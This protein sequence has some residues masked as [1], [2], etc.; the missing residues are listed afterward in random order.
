MTLTTRLSAADN[1]SIDIQPGRW[2]LLLAQQDS[3]EGDSSVSLNG[4]RERVLL[5]AASGR[6]IRYTNSFASKRKLPLE[7]LPT[8]HIR[9][10]VTG[11]SEGDAKWHLGLMLV[12]EMASERG[13]R[14]V[15]LASWHDPS[16]TAYAA[17]VAQAASALAAVVGVP[18][19]PILPKV[20]PEAAAPVKELPALPL[21]FGIWTLERAPLGSGGGVT[22]GSPVLSGSA[23]DVLRFTR[24]GSWTRSRLIRMGWYTLWLVVYLVLSVATL[25]TKLAL[26]NSG[27]MLPNPQIL[28][29]L[30]LGAAGVL[31]ILI[32]SIVLDL[33]TNPS[34]IVVDPTSHSIIG[35][36]GGGERW[37]YASDDVD[38]VYASQVVGQRGEKRTLYHGELNLRLNGQRFFS[39]LRMEQEEE[40]LAERGERPI[41]MIEPLDAGHAETDLQ[42]AALYLADALGHKPCWY[43]QRTQ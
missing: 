17:D 4:A 42:A 9:Q 6:A 16:Q 18:F 8:E 10:I 36:S 22:S 39:V 2:R 3:G 26:P 43:D 12:N 7:T 25:T 13:S 19:R 35:L 32:A 41:D 5:D 37:R 14:W 34:Q 11:W 29:F 27:M 40:R 33:M 21:K 24:A 23:R 31:A 1:L 20:A 15:E 38:S 30:G 28:P